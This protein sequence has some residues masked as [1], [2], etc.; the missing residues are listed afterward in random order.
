MNLVVFIVLY[1]LVLEKCNEVLV[2]N[3]GHFWKSAL[4]GEKG[5]PEIAMVWASEGDHND[6]K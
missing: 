4:Q 1:R 3:L 2:R 6:H 5:G